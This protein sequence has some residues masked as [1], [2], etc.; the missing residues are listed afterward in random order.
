MRSGVVG[1]IPAELEGITPA[2]ARRVRE[3]GFSGVTVQ[4][5]APGAHA[6]PEFGRAR[7]VLA[8]AG[9]AVAQANGTFA[10]LVDPD[11][12]VRRAGI[13]GLLRHHMPAAEALQAKTL[14]VRPGGLN[15]A[16]PWYPH[17]DH[18]SKA[19]FERAAASLA[20]VTAAAEARGLTLAVEGHVLSVFDRPERIGDLLRRIPSQ[21]LTFN[22]DPVNF[23]GSIW[24]AW[25][26]GG[27]YRRLLAAARGRIVTAHWKDYVVDDALV[28]HVTE[29]P[30][31][32][33]VVDHA[34]W[35][36]ELA[37]SSP[38]AWVMLEHLRPA[39]IPAAKR[40]LDAAM[41]AAGL[42][43]DG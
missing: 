31:G 29:V 32:Q 4:L 5:G 13:D 34:A 7:G 25:R 17:P 23:I 42:R 27:V 35:L 3:L 12:A 41:A 43:W 40:A 8:D 36:A 38:D 18:H 24:D 2:A 15:P 11:A 22:L 20:E 28:L 26:P 1:L 39:Q 10:S 9:V 33:G 30:P 37:S 19:A 6:P 14:Y 21:A 16:G